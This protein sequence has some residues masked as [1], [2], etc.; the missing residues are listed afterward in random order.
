MNFGLIKTGVFIPKI[1]VCDVI[2]NENQIKNGIEQAEDKGV[3]VLCFPKMCLTGKTVGDLIYTE[4]VL[5]S[6]L[7]ALYDLVLYS[8]GKKMLIFIGLPYRKNGKVGEYTAV[9]NDG[10]LLGVFNESERV[11][12]C[13][14]DDA[15]FTLSLNKDS[16]AK[17]IVMPSADS[18]Y[19]GRI[20]KT[21]TLMS[22][23]STDK[24]C[25]LIYSNAGEGESTT[26]YVFSGHSAIYENGEKL[27]ENSPFNTGLTVSDIDVEYLSYLRK[28]QIE[29][30]TEYEK[31]EFITQSVNKIDRVYEKY[32]FIKGTDADFIIRL[33]AEGL[34][35]R[36]EHT[37]SKKI[38]LGLSGGLDSTLALIVVVKTAELLGKNKKDII[39][40]TMP[41]FGTSGRT[42]ENSVKLAKAYG[43]TLKKVEIGKSV[44]RHLKDIGHPDDLLDASYENAQ[45]RERTQ[46][47]MDIANYVGGIVVGTGDLSEVALGWSTYNGDHMS[48]YGVNASVP[49]TLVRYL[50]KSVADKSKLKL[51]TVLYDIL[52]TPIS[53]ELLPTESN[54]INQ[55]TEDIV[56][57]YE[58]HDFFLYNMILKGYSPKKLYEIG[59][60]AFKGEYDS[61]T[62]YKWLNTFIRR[63]ITQG[64]KRSCMPDGVKATEISLS[65]RCG[66]SMPSDATYSVFIKELEEIKIN[67]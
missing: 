50:V 39:A 33:Q 60:Q 2:Y 11:V 44:K 3:E 67:G 28:D 64:F 14:N 59:V 30:F 16:G 29:D 35:K 31:I 17:I 27:A 5:N 10:K 34:K 26:D 38:V 4:S 46:V 13:G 36:I 66:Y 57:P 7:N 18:E 49:K 6:S 1:K 43:V 61:E 21:E 54:S 40:I 58:L 15:N 63:F 62:V 48:N 22:A 9:I 25:A 37:C 24:K 41:C 8:S 52:D 20:E 47:L 56:G 23:Y 19:S 12:F 32:P 53:P 51:K 45:A 42:F 65:P 55:K